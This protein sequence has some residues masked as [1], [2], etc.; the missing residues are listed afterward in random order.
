MYYE[1]SK[2]EFDKIM[3]VSRI[4]YTDYELKGN[5]IPVENLMAVIEDLLV[6]YNSKE[7]ELD[8]LQ[9]DLTENY[10]PKKVD[11]GIVEEYFL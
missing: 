4:T 5:L 3:E 2:L 11:L 6:T 9:N 8:D 7:E 1:L 10:E